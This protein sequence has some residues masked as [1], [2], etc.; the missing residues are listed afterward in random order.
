MLVRDVSQ[1]LRV[2]RLMG[3]TTNMSGDIIDVQAQGGFFMPGLAFIFS[4]RR[5]RAVDLTYCHLQKACRIFA[6]VG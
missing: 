2:I 4:G 6:A 1:V 5:A 3:V